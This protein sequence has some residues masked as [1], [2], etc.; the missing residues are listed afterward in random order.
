MGKL[1]TTLTERGQT[2][3]PAAI[4]KHLRLRPGCQLRWQEVSD[5]ECRL[6]IDDG[7]TGPGAEAML[8]YAA[9]FRPTRRSD[10]WMRELREGD[11]D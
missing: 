6:V 10:D 9:Q 1:I 3:V 2:S 4:R 8:G 5:H 11:R 7:T